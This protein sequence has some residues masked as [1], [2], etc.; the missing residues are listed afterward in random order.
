MRRRRRAADRTGKTRQMSMEYGVW[1]M[2][3]GVWSIVRWLRDESLIVVLFL[4]VLLSVSIVV[5]MVTVVVSGLLLVSCC[6]VVAFVLCL[7]AVELALLVG[8]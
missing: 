7:S 6:S 1:S 8:M 3:Y 5:T 2:E 4:V